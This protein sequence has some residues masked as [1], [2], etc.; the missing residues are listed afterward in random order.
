[1]HELA[2]AQSIVEVVEEQANIYQAARVQSIKLR[3]GEAHAIVF[4]SLKY[5]FEMLTSSEPLLEGARLHVETVPHRARCQDCADE[6]AVN[7]FIAQCPRCHA[8]SNNITS[9]LEF[10]I[11]EME[12]EPLA[13]REER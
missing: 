7:N 9:G 1:M 11:F 2:I 6:F 8:W 10:Q 3:I 5:C 4:D 13:Q 12:F